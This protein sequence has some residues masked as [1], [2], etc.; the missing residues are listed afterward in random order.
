MQ[1]SWTYSTQFIHWMLVYFLLD[2]NEQNIRSYICWFFVGFILSLYKI[3]KCKKS[4]I[5]VFFLPMSFTQSCKNRKNRL[6]KKK[7]M[8]I[9]H[10]V[11]NVIFGHEKSIVM[12]TNPLRPGQSATRALCDLCTCTKHAIVTS[13]EQSNYVLN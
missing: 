1:L 5:F 13:A 6:N 9:R 2:L 7:F 4:M 8:A 10:V 12:Y 11:Q 3:K